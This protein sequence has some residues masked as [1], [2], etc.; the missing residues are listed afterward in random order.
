[1]SLNANL[2]GISDLRILRNDNWFVECSIAL[3]DFWIDKESNTAT[4]TRTAEKVTGN[5]FVFLSWHLLGAIGA[6]GNIPVVA[7]RTDCR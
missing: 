4:A 6:W 7:G 1:M 5:L 2:H 3:P